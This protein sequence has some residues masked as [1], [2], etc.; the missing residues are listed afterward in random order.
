MARATYVWDK[1]QQ[2]VVPIEERTDL[3]PQGQ[4]TFGVMSDIQ[5]FVTTDKVEITSRSQLREYEA[6]RGV[7]QCG[8]DWTGSTKPAW[9]NALQK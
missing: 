5:P 6:A 7:K 3:E 1:R 4:K 9:W 8:N 2:K